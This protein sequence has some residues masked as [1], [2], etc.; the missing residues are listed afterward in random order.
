MNKNVTLENNFQSSNLQST[1]STSEKSLTRVFYRLVMDVCHLLFQS[2]ELTSLEKVLNS[3][4]ARKSGI[5][6][7]MKDALLPLVDR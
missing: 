2:S 3:D 6:K 5:L 7:Y 1:C 4:P